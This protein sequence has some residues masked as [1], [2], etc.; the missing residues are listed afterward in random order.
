MI[1]EVDIAGIAIFLVHLAIKQKVREKQL[2]HLA[3]IA[4]KIDKP[5]IITGD[6]NTFAG[7]GELEELCTKL[8]LK[9]ANLLHKSTYPSWNPHHE[10][11]FILHSQHIKINSFAV[12]DVHLSDHMPVMIDFDII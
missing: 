6:F 3:Q 11:D 7:W 9:N 8:K 2:N 12:Y 5:L 10:L 4:E 1:I